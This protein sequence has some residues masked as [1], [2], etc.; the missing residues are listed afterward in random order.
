MLADVR[1][2]R[3][4][5][6]ARHVDPDVPQEVQRQHAR[7]GG[8]ARADGE[9]LG[10]EVGEGADAR[11]PSHDD[12]GMEVAVAVAHGERE[13]AAVRPPLDA[14]VRERGVPRHV[15]VAGQERLD[16]ALV[17]REQREVHRHPVLGEVLADAL[18]DRHHLRIVGHRAEENRRIAHKPRTTGGP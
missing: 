3:E 2:E 4:E 14:D 17:V 10:R 1:V 11:V 12:L 9:R 16:L 18:P 7:L 13:G 6:H 15:D 5:A 8:V